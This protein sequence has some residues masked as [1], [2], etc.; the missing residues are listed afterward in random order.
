LKKRGRL[1]GGNEFVIV[2]DLE[3]GRGH[4]FEGWFNNSASFKEQTLK[5]L[6]TC[7]ICGDIR[8][9]RLLSPVAT[10]TARPEPEKAPDP[11]DYGRLAKEIVHYVNTHFEDVGSN[12]AK[13]ALKM[14][15]GVCEK[16]NIKGSATAAEEKLLRDEKVEF[17]KLPIPR[18]E[19]DKNN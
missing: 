3:C 7:P 1:F 12:F 8:V 10:K 14:Q 19:D 2:F 18:T 16:K 13:E 5:K 17:F 11:I 9:R 15:Y 4:R 6:V